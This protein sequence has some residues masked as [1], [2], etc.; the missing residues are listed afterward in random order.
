MEE[1]NKKKKRGPIRKIIHFICVLVVLLLVV[2]IGLII[3]LAVNIVSNDNFNGSESVQAIA[4]ENKDI[5]EVSN[6]IVCDS[7]NSL[8]DSDTNE[9]NITLD[10]TNMNYM[11]HSVSKTIDLSPLKVKNIYTTYNS[12]SNYSIYVPVE[13]LFFKSCLYGT[14]DIK[15]NSATNNIDINVSKLNLGKLSTNNFLIKNIALKAIKDETINQIFTSVGLESTTTVKGSEIDVSIKSDSISKLIENKVSDTNLEIV[16]VVYNTLSISNNLSYTFTK[17]EIG[18]KANLNNAVGT[19]SRSLENDSLDDVK[20]QMNKLI[21]GGVVNKQNVSLVFNYLVNGYSFLSDEEKNAI[22]ALDLSTIGL[23]SEESKTKYK[24]I[25]TRHDDKVKLYV[26]GLSFAKALLD[27][28]IELS[29]S[30]DSINHEIEKNKCVGL[31]KAFIDRS[32]NSFTYIII[33]DIYTEIH[34]DN[35]DL[36]IL[37]NIN[38]KEVLISMNLN[39]INGQGKLVTKVNSIKLGN[40]NVD[41]SEYKTVLKFLNNN[42]SVDYFTIDDVNEQVTLDFKDRG[43]DNLIQLI[44]DFEFSPEYV[45]SE[46]KFSLVYSTNKSFSDV[47]KTLETLFNN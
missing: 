6:Y 34:D 11:L 33:E 5:K 41:K 24:G 8:K 38:S 46:N 7:L 27:K 14:M 17:E 42:I 29:V 28:K 12:D 1:E 4:K 25:I 2:A 39:K 47:T 32:G 22:K 3:Y 23:T 36:N 26:D 16:D 37:L 35:L 40:I 21:R 45:L 18:L 19:S 43:S 10:E 44:N 9:L 15:Y 31:S 20:L 13:F 30:E